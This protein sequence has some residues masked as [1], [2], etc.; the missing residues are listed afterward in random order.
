[1]NLIGL[2]VGKSI[3]RGDSLFVEKVQVRFAAVTHLAE[4]LSIIIVI[5]IIIIQ[6]NSL[7]F[8][9]R[10]NS[11]K[12][13]YRRHSVDISNYIMEQYNINSKTSKHCRKIY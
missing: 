10:V 11:Y 3:F 4:G 1:M 2:N 12:A 9:C 6:L 5:I 13:N 8:M 7:L